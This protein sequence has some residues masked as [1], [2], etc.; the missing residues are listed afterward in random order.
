M[1]LSLA[2]SP[3]RFLADL[4]LVRIGSDAQ[5]RAE[6]LALRHQRRILERRMAPA[7]RHRFSHYQSVEFPMK[8]NQA[9]C[10]ETF[11]TFA[12]MLNELW[13]QGA[14]WWRRANSSD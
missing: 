6:V 5:L 13:L 14:E 8:L 12:S 10:D 7:E 2:Y 1:L 9:M 3:P 4:C 11:G